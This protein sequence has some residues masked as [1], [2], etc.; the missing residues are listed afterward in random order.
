MAPTAS[1]GEPLR[2][3]MIGCGQISTRF[4]NQ[5][6]QLDAAGW[7]VRFVATCA[8]HEASA[9]AKAEE[10]GCPRWYTDHR[11]LLDDPEVDAVI[12]TTPHALHA[13]MATDAVR[14]GKHLLVEKPLTTR[15]EQALALAEAAR[16]AP[17]VTVMA[18][19]YVD[20][21]P[22]LR[23]L[24][25]ARESYLGKITGVEA[26][27]SFPGPPRSN[28][29]Y[30]ASAEGGA[31]L[32]TMVYPLARVAA[33]MGP[34]RRVTALVNRLI[35]HRITGDGG[36][37][38]SAVDDSVSILLEYPT[39]QQ[40]QLHSVW[41][42]SYMTNGTVLHGRHGAI[43]LSRY[44]QPLVVK[45]DLQAPPD[46][47]PLEYLGIPNCYQVPVPQGT[48]EGEIVAHFLRA[49]RK[50]APLHCGLDVGL[51]I[52]EQQMMAYESARSGKAIDLTTTFDVWWPREPGIMDLSADWL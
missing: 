52:A 6:A 5:A 3:G 11:R 30:S 38:E 40:A 24:D 2:L 14:A 32:D 22:F 28:W 41:A 51:H 47:T 25:F 39:G 27:L 4:F 36:R 12:I 26:E 19:P 46:G 48:V 23:A 1:R 10:R 31:M 42:R 17:E 16:A 20:A 50:E 9:R 29:Y 44:G 7:G 45:S 13:G 18:L 8:A 35:P 33:L 34:A 49:I 43:F 21:P 15:W 37:V